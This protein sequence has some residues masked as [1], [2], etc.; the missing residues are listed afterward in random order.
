VS[1]R[2]LH[3]DLESSRTEPAR[4]C[5]MEARDVPQHRT[6]VKPRKAGLIWVSV[7]PLAMPDIQSRQDGSED[8]GGGKLRALTRGD[9]HGSASCGRRLGDG[10]SRPVEKSDHFI[11]ALKPGNAGGAKGV[12]D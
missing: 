8:G 5:G 1:Q 3:E 12:M 7:P 11:R 2:Q 4:A 9:L 6:K 10:L